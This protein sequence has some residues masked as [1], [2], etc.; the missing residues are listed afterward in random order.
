MIVNP[1]AS[2]GVVAPV[3]DSGEM[4]QVDLIVPTRI[5][6]R[7]VIDN[8]SHH[9]EEVDGDIFAPLIVGESCPCDNLSRIF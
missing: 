5:Y 9:F 7:R 2:G 6:C 1:S 3:E 4:T 8:H